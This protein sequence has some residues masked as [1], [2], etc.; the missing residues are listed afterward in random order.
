MR[1]KPIDLTGKKINMLTV[2]GPGGKNKW[3]IKQWE[4]KCDCGNIAYYI[5]G[6]L[7]NKNPVK[8]CGC[9]KHKPSATRIDLKGKKFGRLKVIS[10]SEE[11]STTNGIIWKCKCDCENFVFVSTRDLRSGNTKSCGCFRTDK[12]TTHGLSGHPLIDTLKGMIRRCYNKNFKYYKN[13]GGRGIK[14]CKEWKNDKKSFYNWAIKNGWKKGLTIDRID[15]DGDYC[16]ENCKFISKRKNSRKTGIKRSNNTSG[17]RGVSLNKASGKYQ[18]YYHKD[19]KMIH[20][21]FFK[22]AKTAAI[23]R[24]QAVIEN[25]LNHLPLNFPKL[26][27]L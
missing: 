7:V 26:K 14:V 27:R 23:V 19:E 21:G 3:N 11:K 12:L 1:G 2:I 17:Y 25:E 6:H 20:L 8:S 18:S 13:Y 22:S 4:C 10:L 15:N 9:L 24:D 16:P 5:T